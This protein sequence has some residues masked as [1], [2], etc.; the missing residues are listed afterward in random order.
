M[1]I[2]QSP[3]NSAHSLPTDRVQ[4][5]LAAWEKLTARDRYLH[6]NDLRRRPAPA[7]FTHEEWW[8]AL[9]LRRNNRLQS[10]GLKDKSGRPFRFNTPDVLAEQLHQID[11]G[12]WFCGGF[13]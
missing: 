10:I 5:V 9:K 12:P 13:A 8:F 4:T 6:W 11:Q 2:P 7:G 3:P 1:K